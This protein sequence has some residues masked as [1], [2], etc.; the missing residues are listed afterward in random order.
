MSN[1]RRPIRFNGNCARCK[2]RVSIAVQP[3]SALWLL[4]IGGALHVDTGTGTVVF[5]VSL[6]ETNSWVP[7][8]NGAPVRMCCDRQVSLRRV[9]G[10]LSPDH[11]CGARCRNSKGFDCT[12]AC[13][14]ANHGCG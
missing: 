5:H 9:I 13:G 6:D 14:G 3:D 2:A 7:T 11:K 12:C 10:R 4:P 8:I 1:T